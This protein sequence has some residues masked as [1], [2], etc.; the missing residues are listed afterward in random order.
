MCLYQR[1]REREREKEKGRKRKSTRKYVCLCLYQR[2]RERERKNETKRERVHMSTFVCVCIRER[3]RERKR[4]QERAHSAREYVS[5]CLYQVIEQR[6]MGLESDEMREY[7]GDRVEDMTS[8]G[9]GN[10]ANGAGNGG[11]FTEGEERQ[12]RSYETGSGLYKSLGGG[13]GDGGRGE[14]T[15]SEVSLVPRLIGA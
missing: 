6:I 9:A 11:G 13:A 2:E 3:E 10:S 12:R 4:E 8:G 15:L 1:E 5:L 7:I 14:R